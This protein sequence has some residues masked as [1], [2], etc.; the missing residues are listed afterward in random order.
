[1]HAAEKPVYLL[2]FFSSIPLELDVF[3]YGDR[4]VPKKLMKLLHPK[5]KSLKHKL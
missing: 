3:E 4:I 5:D 1:M 2:L